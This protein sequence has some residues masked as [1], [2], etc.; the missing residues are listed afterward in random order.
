MRIAFGIYTSR[1]EIYKADVIYFYL[2][3]PGEHTNSAELKFV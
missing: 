2:P 3:N 1:W